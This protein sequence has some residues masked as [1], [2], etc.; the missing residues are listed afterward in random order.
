MKYHIFFFILLAFVLSGSSQTTRPFKK[1]LTNEI[2]VTGLIDTEGP[3]YVFSMKCQING[4]VVYKA[5]SL[6][7][8][9]FDKKAYPIVTQIGPKKFQLL[10]EQ[11]ERPSKNLILHLVI[12]N[13]KIVSKKLIP[14]F[15]SSFINSN[16]QR[17]YCG[18]YDN[19]QEDEH[20][21][22]SY[23]PTLFFID[24]KK[25]FLLDSNRTV[26]YNKKVW[27]KFYGFNPNYKLSLNPKY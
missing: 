5:D 14:S 17:V 7:E 12:E 1:N 25:G 3:D 24:S 8:F 13:S 22:V 10:L 19:N 9:E 16:N 15:D 2:V 20:K 18:I 26:L 21:R 4:K 6:T 11:N 27:G 23:I